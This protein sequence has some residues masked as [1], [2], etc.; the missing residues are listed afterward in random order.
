M[1]IP[2]GSTRNT[3]SGNGTV[4]IC[5]T[6]FWTGRAGGRSK[7]SLCGLKRGWRWAFASRGCCSPDNGTVWS[8][9]VVAGSRCSIAFG[10]WISC[11]CLG[12][13]GTKYL[14]HGLCWFWSNF[15]FLRMISLYF[16]FFVLIWLLVF[17]SC[18]LFSK[19]LNAEF[20]FSTI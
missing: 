2:F 1:A 8:S 11:N 6:R 12:I 10:I 13:N 18:S 15:I 9:S 4:C 19:S 20:L 3:S 7:S 5:R 14:I 17:I 16:V